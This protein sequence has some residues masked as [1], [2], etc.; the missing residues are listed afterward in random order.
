MKRL[1][2]VKLKEIDIM[3]EIKGWNFLGEGASKIGY[4]KKDKVIKIPVGHHEMDENTPNYLLDNMDEMDD[5]VEQIVNYNESLVWSIGQF[6]MEVYVWEKL[7]E[8]EK[9]G[10]DISGFARI[11]DY[12][13]DINGYFVI[14]QELSDDLDSVCD[15]SDEWDDFIESLDEVRG[16]LRRRWNIDLRDI[17]E[18]NCGYLNGRIV[19]FDLGLSSGALYDYSAYNDYHGDDYYDGWDED[20]CN[21]ES[22]YDLHW[23]SEDWADQE[24]EDTN[25]TPWNDVNS[26]C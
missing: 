8:L 1:K 11:I 23:H 18:G 19:C 26:W 25:Y 22:S 6:A 14:E 17:R 10:Y 20:S 12:Y 15:I 16:E 7:L 3:K 2:D 4:G 5:L 13:Q 9:E 21:E 24:A